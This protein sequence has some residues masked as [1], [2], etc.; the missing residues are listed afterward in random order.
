[1]SDGVHREEGQ[2]AGR[3]GKGVSPGIYVYTP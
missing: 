2:P 3:V 1:M